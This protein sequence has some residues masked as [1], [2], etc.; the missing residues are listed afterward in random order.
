MSTYD[1]T[2][3]DPLRDGFLI[4][5][6]SFDGPGGSRANTTLRLYGRGALEWG[7]AVDENLVRL[8]ETFAGST[9]P[10]YPLP[11]QLW[12]CIRYYWHDTNATATSG[13][14]VYNLDLKK[15]ELLNTNGVVAAGPTANPSIGSYY[16]ST[17]NTTLYRWDTAYKQAASAYMPRLFSSSNLG[18]AAPTKQPEHE[19]Y[20]WDQFANSGNGRWVVPL[21]VATQLTQ[22]SD[23]QTGT[24][25]FD[26]SVGKLKIW[27]GTAWKEILGPT[28]G[29]NSA[30]SGNIDMANFSILNLTSGPIAAGEKR[31]VNG[32]TVYAYLNSSLSSLGS[33]Y[34][35]LTGGTITGN[36]GVNG[37]CSVTGALSASSNLTIGGTLSAPTANITT[38]NV[39]GAATHNGN[40][41]N[42]VGAPSASDDA[43]TKSY[44][45]TGIA[46]IT[47]SI[48]GINASNV[49]QAY[50]GSGPY[51]A[52]DICVQGS[53]IFIA[54]VS[55][56]APPPSANWRMVYPAAFV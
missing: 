49:V 16:Y 52:G 56:T 32:G 43:A 23:P 12:M 29:G 48:G 9:A 8:A 50:S 39:S 41:I 47:S 36:L 54:I 10:L 19:L 18:G 46:S 22:P 15:W 27:T 53:N 20:V 34:L 1:I 44:V 3:T 25:W 11:G 7:E 40:R 31:A 51:K 2:P 5:P 21:T 35:P 38:L 26:M 6:G 30:V 42:H 37:T 55:G 17:A 14:W 24:L 4:S 45:D 13:W 33:V 28:N